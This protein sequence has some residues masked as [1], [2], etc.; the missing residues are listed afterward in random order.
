MRRLH[1]TGLV[2]HRLLVLRPQRRRDRGRRV[3][4][5]LGSHA[6]AH[7]LLRG[8]GGRALEIP[9]STTAI[10]NLKN[11]IDGLDFRRLLDDVSKALKSQ[12]D[13]PQF[14]SD[15]R[16]TLQLEQMVIEGGGGGSASGGD[17]K[18]VV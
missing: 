3:R 4:G 8:N 9:T 17:R 12:D 5:H 1:P 18:S 14:E 7:G 16:A 13:L 15:I 11:Q 2:G 10:Q 6:H